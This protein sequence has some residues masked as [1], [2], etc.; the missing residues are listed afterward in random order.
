MLMQFELEKFIFSLLKANQRSYPYYHKSSS[1]V[2]CTLLHFSTAINPLI[3]QWVDSFFEGATLSIYF[4][5]QAKPN[6]IFQLFPI[7]LSW[8][9]L[10]SQSLGLDEVRMVSNE[11]KFGF[12]SKFYIIHT[13]ELNF[14]VQP[15]W[16]KIWSTWVQRQGTDWSCF[17]LVEFI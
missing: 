10:D 1:F 17:G 14:W 4:G 16:S 12:I 7:E 6:P 15:L 9:Q 11:S 2:L 8:D 3:E 13:N 5:V